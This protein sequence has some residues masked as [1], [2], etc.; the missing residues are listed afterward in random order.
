MRVLPFLLCLVPLANCGPG[1][2]NRRTEVAR[3]NDQAISMET[4]DATLA[5]LGTQPGRSFHTAD[6]RRE[7]L[8][9]MIDQELLFQEA[10]R[11]D[12]VRK[13]ERLQR[14]IARE[15]LAEKVGKERYQPTDEEVRKFFD[16]KRNELERVRVSHILIKPEKPGDGSSESAARKKAEAILATIRKEGEKADF[17][18]LAVRHS[19]DPG[20]K[21]AGGDVGFFTR[22]KMVRE[23]SDAAFALP[24][25][26]AVSGAVKSPFGYHILKLTGEQ[27]GFEHFRSSIEWQI[28][29]EKQREKAD[30]LLDGLR[31]DA[32]IRIHEERL[33]P[34]TEK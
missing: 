20:S 9:E 5:R 15:F 33:N 16:E 7:L 30:K 10:L 12:Y 11:Q 14:E 17:A 34:E 28:A 13:S 31:R 27:R 6:G 29:Q 23:F 8:R 19:E 26:G 21:S 18:G 3:V 2:T 22:D 25:I 32:K 24:R 4:F 1:D